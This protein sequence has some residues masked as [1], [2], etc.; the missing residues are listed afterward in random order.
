MGTWKD[1]S[2]SSRVERRRKVRTG[3]DRVH[4]PAKEYKGKKPWMD[5][6][7][8]STADLLK[9]TQVRRPYCER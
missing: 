3:E 5:A 2:S 7:T 8:F 6:L 9:D 4:V 1:H